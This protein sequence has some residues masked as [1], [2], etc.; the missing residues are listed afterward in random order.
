MTT[1]IKEVN[2][3]SI[4]PTGVTLDQFERAIKAQ[5]LAQNEQISKFLAVLAG[6][7]VMYSVDFKPTVFEQSTK[8]SM[9]TQKLNY[10]SFTKPLSYDLSALG[11]I[12]Y[13]VEHCS[14]KTVYVVDFM[15]NPDDRQ[16]LVI[17]RKDGNV[18]IPA[19]STEEE[20]EL[21]NADHYFWIG[22]GDYYSH[23]A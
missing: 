14:E 13:A 16:R 6:M 23:A 22:N 1:Q 9:F 7:P 3:S 12:L 17:A 19:L 15:K 10:N 4:A 8:L 2:I 21:P 20:A 5:G 18:I 11:C